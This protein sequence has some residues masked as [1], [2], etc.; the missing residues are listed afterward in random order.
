MLFF[1]PV[2]FSVLRL[3]RINFIYYIHEK[4]G[5]DSAGRCCC[6]HRLAALVAKARATAL[7]QLSGNLSRRPGC[8]RSQEAVCDLIPAT[9]GLPPEA[10]AVHALQ[11]IVDM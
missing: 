6:C 9:S 3:L 7:T 4:C 1:F 11:R 8:T 5:S 2:L 10:D